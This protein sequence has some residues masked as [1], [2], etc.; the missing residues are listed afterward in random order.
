VQH[1]A[2]VITVAWPAVTALV[3]VAW[4]DASA[5][6]DAHP[7]LAALKK[8]LQK[9]GVSPRSTLQLL[10][11]IAIGKNIAVPPSLPPP[12]ITTTSLE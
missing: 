3:N 1:P 11:Q 5:Y 9:Y 7:R 4:D 10:K 2:L 8:L 12:P 6:A